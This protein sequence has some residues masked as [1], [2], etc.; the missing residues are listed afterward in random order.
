MKST[1]IL[2]ARASRE[3]IHKCVAY[4]LSEAVNIFSEI[5]KLPANKLLEIFK[6]YEQPS[7]GR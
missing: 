1:Y 3:R 6:V 5:K 7:N 2:E 4:S